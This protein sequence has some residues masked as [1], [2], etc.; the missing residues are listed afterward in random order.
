MTQK[1]LNNH[2]L[3]TIQYC[4]GYLSIWILLLSFDMAQDGE[5]V[6]PFRISDFV[7]RIFFK[8]NARIN[9]FNFIRICR[10]QH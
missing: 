2:L 4:L 1:A 10:T 9:G 3:S 8:N 6:E 5:L 7:L